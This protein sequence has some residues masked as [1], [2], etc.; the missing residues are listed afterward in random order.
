MF[1]SLFGSFDTED[2][3]QFE[4]FSPLLL[5]ISVKCGACVLLVVVVSGPFM[6]HNFGVF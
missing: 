3:G 6:G 1:Q 5:S 4:T 2:D